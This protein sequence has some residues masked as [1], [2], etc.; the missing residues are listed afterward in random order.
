VSSDEGVIVRRVLDTYEKQV[1]EE[2]EDLD[3]SLGFLLGKPGIGVF[4]LNEVMLERAVSLSLQNLD[5]KPF[6]QAILAA[7]LVRA[8]ALRAEGASGLCFCELDAN[9]QPWDRNGRKK[10]PLTS[11]YDSTHV[12]VYGDFSTQ[13]PER[14]SS[15]PER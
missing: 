15:F 5:L 9:L 11:L 4:P 3:E 10:E 2:L 8:E 6:D 13:T 12:W 1:L 7:V 14:R